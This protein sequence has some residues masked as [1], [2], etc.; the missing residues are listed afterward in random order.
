MQDW[1]GF[2]DT[3]PAVLADP[4][5]GPVFP[6]PADYLQVE[7]ELTSQA[8]EDTPILHDFNIIWDCSNDIP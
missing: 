5:Q 4:P 2:W 1:F 6:N 7:F 3:S 8:Q